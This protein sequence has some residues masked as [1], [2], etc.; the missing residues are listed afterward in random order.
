MSF[1]VIT[2]TGDRPVPFQL[3]THFM[4]RQTL[5]PDEWIVVDDGAVPI[6]MPSDTPFLK[7]IRRQ[8]TPQKNVHTL[9][10][11]M[12]EALS[13]V[14]T[15]I[16]IMMEDDDWY[17]ADYLE[18]MIKL[19]DQYKGVSLIGQGE[20]V[21]YHI[22]LKKY[23][24]VNNRDRASFCQTGFR[25]ELIPALT[26]ICKASRDP[27]IDLKLW[28]GT[29]DKFLLLGEKLMCVGMKGLEGRGNQ[30][31]IG[32]KG[33]HPRYK[34]DYGLELLGELIGEDVLLYEKFDRGIDVPPKG[35]SSI[36]GHF[37]RSKIG[38]RRGNK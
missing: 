11:Q 4:Q 13:S 8:S 19:F 33:L 7:Y 34:P 29:K 16:V 5:K 38:E 36:V 31:T 27:F 35:G 10:V 30:W 6:P 21:Y 15:D 37:R 2:P 20:S 23:M 9:P 14:T 32:R 12:I 28:R 3:C 17:C 18:K 1:S 22:P 26:E 25:S 24:Y